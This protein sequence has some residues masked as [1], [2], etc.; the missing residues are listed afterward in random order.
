MPS[1]AEELAFR[2]RTLVSAQRILDAELGSVLHPSNRDDLY[3]QRLRRLK[4]YLRNSIIALER[5][6]EAL[7]IA[8]TDDIVSLHDPHPPSPL[9]PGGYASGFSPS[10]PTSTGD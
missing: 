7:G 4:T 3:V 5:R 1:E 8:M 6:M 10:G 2:Y 9:D